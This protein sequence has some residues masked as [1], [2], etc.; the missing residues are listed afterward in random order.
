[1]K[2]IVTCLLLICSCLTP[3]SALAGIDGKWTAEFQT[4]GK[5]AAANNKKRSSTA[6][7]NLKSEDGKLTGSV[8]GG[9]KQIAIQDGKLDGERFSFTT[10]QK[11]KRGE[12]KMM[13]TGTVNGD[14]ITGTRS[15]EGTK[16]SASFTAKRS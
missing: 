2:R 15:R 11:S 9:R 10:I 14:Q 8:S 1:M 3:L 4:R 13:W 5:K 7:L 12:A 6:T 16:R